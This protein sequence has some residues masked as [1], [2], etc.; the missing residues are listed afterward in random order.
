[1]PRHTS[2]RRPAGRRTVFAV[3]LAALTAAL[4]ACSVP[5]QPSSVGST[6]RPFTVNWAGNI[7]SLDPAFACPGDDNSLAGNFYGRLVKPST[8]A[9]QDGFTTA[10]PDPS[11]VEP[12]LAA[13]WKVSDGG[14]TYTFKLRPGKK[15]ANG[16]PLDA[17]AVKYS[18]D[19]TLTMGACGS[20]SMQLGMT[21]PPLIVGVDAPDSTTV[22]VRLRQPYPA[23]LYSLAQSRGSIYDPKE[24]EAHGGVQP[25][26]PNKWLQSHTAGSSGPYVL[27]EY[28]PNNHA[29]LKRN[30]NYYGKPAIEPVVRVNFVSSVSSLLV[31]AE[32]RQADVTLGL[33]PQSVSQLSK[34]A[35]CCKVVTAASATPV[36]V[37]MNYRGQVTGNAKFREALTYAVPYQDIINKVAYGYGD[38]YYGPVVPGMAGYKAGLE[39][40]RPYDPNKAKRLLAASGVK[41]PALELMINPTAPGVSDVAA[42]LQSAWQAI[43]VKVTIAAKPP[44]DFS[45]LFNDGKYQAAL[46]FENSTPIGSYE[47]R[48]KMT[49]GSPFNNQHI[50]IPG[51]TPLLHKLDNTADVAQQQP[52]LDDLVSTWLEQSPTVILY[53]AR[54]TAVVSPDVKHFGYAPNLPF[55]EWGR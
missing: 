36:T 53:R 3:G 42:L 24:V 33:P 47:L 8:T 48:K 50:C 20:L 5:D 13:G 37:S 21:K 6:N 23:M 27:A 15:F 44:T 25:N 39:P 34:K 30:P 9:D 49:C 17:A 45:T 38:S 12:D 2:R 29:I 43:G 10:N 46:L 40:P 11:K 28:L 55:S 22:V 4:A 7:S 35:S 41:S 51:T 1:M 32:S 54:F 16:D 52:V 18:I 19:R 26:T 14:K 31:Q